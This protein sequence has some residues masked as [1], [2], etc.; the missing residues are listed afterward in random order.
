MVG[1][2]EATKK[3]FLTLVVE[4]PNIKFTL[5]KKK[6]FAHLGSYFRPGAWRQRARMISGSASQIILG[7][8]EA[9]KNV[10]HTLAVEMPNI[11]FT[12]YK[13]KI[14]AHLGAC[15]RPG[16]WPQRARMIFLSGSHIVL[17]SK[18]AT[19]KVSLMLVLEM[20]NIKFTLY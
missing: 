17:G 14:F 15:F 18:E 19:K 12:L 8:K 3:V 10:S 11:E 6:T 7:S 4:M 20:S 5:Y 16:V 2:K 9:T 13:K 1:S